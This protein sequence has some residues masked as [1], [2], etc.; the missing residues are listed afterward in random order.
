MHIPHLSPR[1]GSR[2]WI[3]RL[4]ATGLLAAGPVAA[5]TSVLARIENLAPGD[6][7]VRG[8]FLGRA[9]EIRVEASAL[10]R[11]D[12]YKKSFQM[13]DA[14]ILD[15]DSREVVWQLSD[16][17]SR[18]RGRALREIDE[19]VRLESGAY[20][21]YYATFP[22]SYSEGRQD[23][24]ES[25][26]RA[27]SRMFGWDEWQDYEDAIDELS[28]MVRGDG[29]ALPDSVVADAR[30]ALLDRAL[31]TIPARS[32]ST[33]QHR[34][35]VFERAMD[36]DV[37]AVGELDSDSGY[38]Y[39]W[40]IDT[41]TREKVWELTWEGSEAGGGAK[42]NRLAHRRIHLPAGSYAAYYVTDGSHSPE[43]WNALP[44][45]DPAFWGLTLWPT[46][47]RQKRFVKDFEYH[48]VPDDQLVI[49]ELTRVRD[50]DHQSQGFTLD[51]PMSVR[52]YAVGEGVG[53]TMA[54]YGW[55]VDARTR[56]QVW[57]MEYAK[58]EHAGGAYKN[59][60][61]DEILRL[62]PGSY[63]VSFVTDG[64]HSY[65]DWNTA[66]PAFP[67]RWGIS[68][69]GLEGFDR[70]AVSAYR[71]DEDPAVLAR[72]SRV[73]SHSSRE[74]EFSVERESE[75][76]VYALG[77][78]THGEMYDYAWIEDASGRVVWQMTYPMTESA[79][80]ASKNR[81]YQGILNL[82]PGDYVLHYRTDDSHAYRDWNA[83]PPR[84]PESWGVQVALVR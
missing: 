39:G 19:K 62:E 76:S 49:A 6:V 21:A 42:K 8:F 75:V 81:Q 64:S 35:F 33:A 56:R 24:W 15:A 40:I 18:S 25:A 20:E 60:V 51:R 73:R 61:A 79:G 7:E 5:E 69:F 17:H 41:E 48:H 29:R 10:E 28:L 43:H 22:M 11:R 63:I 9:Q 84:D 16:A 68:I 58:T 13:A 55:I 14:W 65:R 80:G 46:D 74:L 77:E 78:G 82:P 71:E 23:W 53:N 67:E 1:S 70:S 59:R 44:P 27:L 38:D 32:D 72:I 66:P 26:A 36:L 57:S 30:A 52:V 34:G 3:V 45:R 4:V 47:P 83:S 54:D 50:D 2:A 37:Y 12:R 31:V